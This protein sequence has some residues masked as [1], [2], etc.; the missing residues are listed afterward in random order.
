[1]KAGSKAVLLGF[2]TEESDKEWMTYRLMPFQIHMRIVGTLFPPT[3]KNMVISGASIELKECDES[4]SEFQI[5]NQIRVEVFER[6]DIFVTLKDSDWNAYPSGNFLYSLRLAGL[7]APMPAWI[8]DVLAN[9][10]SGMKMRYKIY[11]NQ[12]YLNGY[13]APDSMR[14]FYSDWFTPHTEEINNIQLFNV[15]YRHNTDIK[16]FKHTDFWQSFASDSVTIMKNV[17]INEE[18][19]QPNYAGQIQRANTT[20]QIYRQVDFLCRFE[21]V[22]PLTFMAESDYKLVSFPN[23]EVGI[24]KDIAFGIDFEKVDAD[25]LKCILTIYEEPTRIVGCSI[26]EYITT[27]LS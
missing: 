27:E 17:E 1:M 20:Y 16:G 12:K 8:N 3:A 11:M 9:Y 19:T 6:S 14:L 22:E 7:D 24:Y 4:V 13:D 15:S 26:D 23:E 25:T 5:T 2:N 21:D 18:N 10:Q